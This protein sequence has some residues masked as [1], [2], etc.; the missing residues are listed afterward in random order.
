M[1]KSRVLSWMRQISTMSKLVTGVDE[2]ID[3]LKGNLYLSSA[4]ENARHMATIQTELDRLTRD[5]E[6]MVTELLSRV[7]T[8]DLEGVTT[9]LTDMQLRLETS[10]RLF[11]EW[12]KLLAYYEHLTNSD[13]FVSEGEQGMTRETLNEAIENAKQG[14]ELAL[15]SAE[16]LVPNRSVLVL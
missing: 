3:E 7:N 1:T 12:R 13:G 8:T 11:V 16:D 5:R 2:N 6:K 14:Y 10:D 15:K 9:R 4:V